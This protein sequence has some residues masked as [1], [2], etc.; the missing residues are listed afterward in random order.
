[1]MAEGLTLEDIRRS[2]VFFKNGIDRADQELDAVLDG[3][4]AELVDRPFG[5]DRRDELSDELVQLRERTEA[6]IRDLAR[7][8]SALTAQA[9]F[10]E[11]STYSHTA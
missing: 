4:A 7:L 8:G 5:K 3:Y 2:F 10:S 9:P 1:M 6:L 11:G